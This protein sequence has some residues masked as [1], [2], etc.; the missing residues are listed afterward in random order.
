MK[1]VSAYL[2]CY[3]VTDDVFVGSDSERYTRL[4]T[5]WLENSFRRM[6][7]ITISTKDYIQSRPPRMMRMMMRIQTGVVT[8]VLII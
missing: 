7:G 3:Q 1:V 4:V 2:L 8:L 5:S 6:V